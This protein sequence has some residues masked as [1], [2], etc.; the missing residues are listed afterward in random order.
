MSPFDFSY[1]VQNTCTRLLTITQS[2][3]AQGEAE[4][5]VSGYGKFAAIRLTVSPTQITILDRRV[6][7]Q[8]NYEKGNIDL[9]SRIAV[10]FSYP[11]KRLTVRPAVSKSKDLSPIFPIALH[12]YRR[13]SLIPKWYDHLAF[14]QKSSTFREY[15]IRHLIWND[16][17]CGRNTA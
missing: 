15:T 9:R 3:H 10:F 13:T 4:V 1:N 2:H 12:G 17:F 5:A 7:C 11:I 6:L 16:R 14:N 8:S